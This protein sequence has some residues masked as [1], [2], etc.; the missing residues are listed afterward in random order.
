MAD[1]PAPASTALSHPIWTVV[2][3]GVA[4]FVLMLIDSLLA[5]LTGRGL[6]DRARDAVAQVVSLV[7]QRT[8]AASEVSS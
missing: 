5:V 4:A 3:I 2:V 8:A 6:V 7:P 1:L